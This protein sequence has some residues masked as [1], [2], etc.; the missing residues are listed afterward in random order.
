[1]NFL[2]IIYLAEFKHIKQ[3]YDLKLGTCLSKL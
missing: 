3:F 1:M 2:V